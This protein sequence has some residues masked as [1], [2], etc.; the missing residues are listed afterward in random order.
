MTKD[1]KSGEEE[2]SERLRDSLEEIG[3]T[4]VIDQERGETKAHI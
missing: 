4:C 2:Y 1:T 3:N